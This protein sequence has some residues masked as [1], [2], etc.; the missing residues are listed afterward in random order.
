[1]EGTE[2]MAT[3]DLCPLDNEESDEVTIW[4]A[5][6]SPARDLTVFS[7]TERKHLVAD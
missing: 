4:E 2:G 5:G 7:L 1:M 6:D 3:G